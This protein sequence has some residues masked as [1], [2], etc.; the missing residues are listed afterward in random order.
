MNELRDPRWLQI[1]LLGLFL[2]YGI[3]FLGWD[4]NTPIYL[5]ALISTVV[6]QLL[7][8]RIHKASPGSWKSAL[9]SGLGLCLLLKVNSWEW[10]VLAGILTISGKFLIRY[11]GGHIYNPTNLGIILMSLFGW[12]WISPG[13]WGTG[14]T[15]LFLLLMGAAGILLQVKRWDVAMAFLISLFVLEALRVVGYLGWEWDVLVH[16]FGSGTLLLFAFFMITDP[17]T[18]P[19][20]RK[21]RIIWGGIIALL[22]FVLAQFFYLY[23]AP[24][25]ALFIAS[26]FTPLINRL[27]QGREFSW[28]T[29]KSQHYE[30]AISGHIHGPD[31]L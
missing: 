19:H 7:W 29:S 20:S 24:L 4:V 18:T 1:F 9:I 5:A 30:K 17:K 11:K 28:K 23:Q 25:I 10:M 15:F 26:S 12:G 31:S 27:Y 3:G 14:N 16:R 13:Q 22:S 21:G 2:S 8:V 6:V